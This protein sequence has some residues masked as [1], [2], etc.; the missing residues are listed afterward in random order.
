MST[1][2]H[3]LLEDPKARVLALYP[4]R[5]LIQDQLA[6]WN[7][8]FSPLDLAVGYI[9]GGVMVSA[10]AGILAASHV[11][12]MTPDV[13]HAWL[14]GNAS[15]PAIARFL[16]RLLL[17][18]LDE[19]HV[20]EG[21]FGTNMAYFLRRLQAVASPLQIISSTATVGAPDGFIER[22]SG[23]RP[24]VLG[25][26]DDGSP[27]PPKTVLAARDDQGKGFQTMANLL[28]DLARAGLGRFLAF[29][30][31]RSMVEQ[32]VAASRRARAEE[33]DESDD[34]EQEEES[35]DEP[36]AGSRVA[37]QA[38]LPYRAGY[39]TEDRNAIQAALACGELAGVAST[40]AL[41][42]GLD[43]GEI[44][45][46]VLLNLPPT[47]K[48]FWQRLG[49]AGRRRDAVCVILDNAGNL[50]RLR[51]GLDGYLARAAEPSWLYL[52]NRYIQY[53][54]ALCAALELRTSGR[55][56]RAT[57]WPFD[58]LP[59]SFR[60]LL[61]NELNPTE[62]VA[63]DLYPLKQRAEGGPHH[64]FPLRTGMD[65]SFRV[66]TPQGIGLGTVTFAQLLREAY[67]G[68]IHY[69]MARPYRVFQYKYRAGEVW[70]RR[71]KHWT[72]KP[73]SQ[74]MVFPRFQGGVF[75]V[76][77]AADAFVAEAEMQ[78]SERV[79]GFVEQRGSV[80]EEH[81]YGPTSPY[82]GRDLNRFFET[83]GVCWRVPG[84]GA[85]G[86]A[87]ALAVAEAFCE[88][89]GVQSRDVGV[90]M[91]HS[92]SSPLGAET[93]Q[94]YCVFDATSGSLRLTQRLG[95]SFADVVATA[96]DAARRNGEDE[97]AVGLAALQA[98]VGHLVSA[99]VPAAGPS[100]PVDSEWVRVIAPGSRAVFRGQ[101]EPQ[102]VEVVGVRY[103]PQG[104]MYELR[105]P[106]PGVKWIVNTAVVEA[107]HG[108]SEERL[109]NPTTGDLDDI[110]AH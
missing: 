79:L 82:Y 40:S 17:L 5:A 61:A 28:R 58:S 72:T 84:R 71:T 93:C 41:E 56:D 23:R 36:H 50:A 53:T 91:F 98:F 52:D 70:V 75:S 96:L 88:S 46:V 60:R 107:I 90:G 63:P 34:A 65:Q 6:K 11:I 26:G 81:R 97:I 99:P 55:S 83:T 7:A 73:I 77:L 15:S 86:E 19:A 42:L 30:D 25:G 39:E 16:S 110:G 2:A 13:A 94:G 95:E 109:F 49:R 54:N 87:V 80:K 106:E 76:W 108:V 64:E 47:A 51:G 101:V 4:A 22:L 32:L 12:L 10:R 38:L 43:I 89:F 14:L 78:V 103:T 8:M 105:S 68:A 1:A 44:D 18:V 37:G 67:P 74:A 100:S 33:T 104:L 92:K 59:E 20:Y 57:G 102:E 9:D 66:R 69:Y 3:L 29:G 62:V 21:V 35:G 27:A 24:V 45:I 85:A 31:S 48:A